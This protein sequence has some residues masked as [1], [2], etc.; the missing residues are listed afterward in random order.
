VVRFEGGGRMGSGVEGHVGVES[1]FLRT[2]KRASR[3][4]PASTHTRTS[5]ARQAKAAATT[6]LVGLEA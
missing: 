6:H 2:R 5:K 4:Q 1:L 3:L